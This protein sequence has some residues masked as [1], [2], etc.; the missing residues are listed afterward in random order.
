MHTD[1]TMG[2]IHNGLYWTENEFQRK[3]IRQLIFDKWK[4]SSKVKVRVAVFG[5]L[6][7]FLFL[8]RGFSVGN[9]FK[10]YRGSISHS[11][12]STCW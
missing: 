6:Q 8:Y 3:I 7:M 11:K 12:G 4:M 9:L 1:V 10:S 5:D 2:S